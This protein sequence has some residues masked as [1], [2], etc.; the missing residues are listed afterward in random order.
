VL[1]SPN[2]LLGSDG[3]QPS[4][5]LFQPADELADRYR[6]VRLVAQGGMGEVYEAQ[7]LELNERVGLKTVRAEIATDDRLVERFKREIYLARRVT[8]PNVC[9]IFDVGFHV[10]RTEDGIEQRIIFLTMELLGG[11]TLS[12][13]LR[14]RGR[15][16]GEAALPIVR[17]M[18][19]AL[20]AAHQAGVVHRDFKSD[21]VMLVPAPDVEG[22]LR[23]VV[24]DFGLARG[25]S[26]DPAAVALTGAAVV[27]SP[28]YMAPEQVEGGQAGPPA[29]IYALGV[30][31][32]EMVTGQL[33]FV[34][35][36]TLATAVKRL[37]E[38]PPSARKLV[39]ELDARWDAVILR[40]LQRHPADRFASA[41]EVAAALDGTADLRGPRPRRLRRIITTLVVTALLIGGGLGAL[42]G[43]HHL[44]PALAG[45]G[46][47]VQVHKRRTVA[48]IG[49]KN[50]SGRPDAGWLSTAFAEFLSTELAASDRLRAIPEETVARM[51]MELKLGECDSLARDTLARVRANLGIDLVVVGSYLALGEQAGGRVRLD[52]RVQDASAGETLTSI[53]ETGTQSELLELVARAGAH[54]RGEL[55]A[56]P[57]TPE[58]VGAARAGLPSSPEAAR[59]Y[60]E[61]LAHLH[62]YEA[63]P[64]RDLFVKALAIEPRSP[65]LHSALAGVWRGLGYDARAAEEAKKALDLSAGLGREDQLVVEGRYREA[66][67]DWPRAVQAYQDLVRLVPDQIDYS[68]R[69]V[70]SQIRAGLGREALVTVEALHRLPGPAAEDARIDLAEAKVAEALSDLSRQKVAAE[71][72]LGKA[73]ARGALVLAG[74]SELVVG[75]ALLELGEYDQAVGAYNEARQMYVS[76]GYRVGMANS[77]NNLANVYYNRGDRAQGLVMY[78]DALAIYRELGDRE[79]MAIA[80]NNVGGSLAEQG[81]TSEGR[82]YLQ[83]ALAL[84]REIGHRQ[85]VATT[86]ENIGLLALWEGDLVGARRAFEEA[87][88]IFRD[89]GRRSQTGSALVGLAAVA[90]YAGEVARARTYFDESMT[91]RVELG[92]TLAVTTG[93]ADLAEILMEQGKPEEA[94]AVLRDALKGVIAAKVNDAEAHAHAVL[95]QVLIALHRVDEAVAEGERAVALGAR[96]QSLDIRTETQVALA[97]ADV[98]AGRGPDALR[99]LA[100]VLEQTSRLGPYRW[101]V[102]GRL[103]ASRAEI[104]IGRREAGR[105]HLAQLAKEAGAH[106]F[107]LVAEKAVAARR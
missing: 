31:L 107:A 45:A 27:G 102:E 33:P 13:R 22:G 14:Q 77:L 105:A 35:E 99:T 7:D 89:V 2:N 25:P 76:T 16:V 61:G 6:I 39:P 8:H 20:S 71:R 23:V 4:A 68:M 81:R 104:A 46:G 24:T 3:Q 11:E 85:G 87:L 62:R 82:P 79:N 92:Q 91:I 42:R 95:S 50:L 34:G 17:Q 83:E 93:R 44:A 67:E 41:A 18:V 106:G 19:G 69:L 70:R 5:P 96:I 88:A 101:L 55:G 73:K 63:V 30:V 1:R 48:V 53:T 37:K 72:A 51:N 21:N 38:P 74:D 86:L 28:G 66:I 10:Q 40:C 43:W 94:E 12:Q 56:E 59:L 97:R 15:F 54:L 65:L 64:A 9:R 103:V 57:L 100:P 78:R 47:S 36:T 60:A 26:S 90:L 52:V 75:N 80:L 29:D 49:F 32:F 58:R 84:R 98:A